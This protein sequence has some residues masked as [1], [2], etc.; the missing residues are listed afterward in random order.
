MSTRVRKFLITL[1]LAAALASPVYAQEPTP[2][3]QTETVVTL[4]SGLT[5][6]IEHRWDVGELVTSLATLGILAVLVLQWWY[7]EQRQPPA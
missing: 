2:T 3:P 5:F 4:S 6:I 7:R 1:I